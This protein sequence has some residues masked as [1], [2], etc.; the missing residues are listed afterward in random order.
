MLRF[1]DPRTH[2]L[3]ISRRTSRVAEYPRPQERQMTVCVGAICLFPGEIGSA[4]VTASD[5][6]FTD[7]GQ[8]IEYEPYQF[9]GR[10]LGSRAIVLVADTIA[11]HSEVLA[12]IAPEVE[13]NPAMAI[14]AIADRYGQLLRDHKAK[15]SVT[16]ALI[17]WPYDTDTF[18][19]EQHK[20]DPNLVASVE[21][22]AQ[23]AW[24]DMAV[25]AIV[26][27][28]DGPAPHLYVIDTNGMTTCYDAI[29]F[30]AIGSGSPHAK[31]QFMLRNFTNS[32]G[33]YPSLYLTYLAKK[34]AEI[35]PGVGTNTDM[36]V[37]TESHWTQLY[38]DAVGLLE[39][40]HSE[41]QRKRALLE[42]ATIQ[43]YQDRDVVRLTEA[44]EAI[45]ASAVESAIIDATP[46]KID[47]DAST[48]GPIPDCLARH[49][50]VEEVPSG[51]PVV[52][53]A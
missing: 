1:P 47:I 34:S 19:A 12:I 40:T 51:S 53:P 10:M 45:T 22:K 24:Q 43:K 13:K 28:F 37:L 14:K 32:W 49:P 46:D 8:G 26:A 27:G 29:G 9:K 25:S 16:L 50:S 52:S 23:V 30:A 31:A 17:P 21:N 20:L 35:A 38:P 36:F 5:R 3:V 4:I 15:R 48:M 11:I 44:A 33:Y 18:V 2:P 42:Q 7:M 39:R 6:M 41:Y